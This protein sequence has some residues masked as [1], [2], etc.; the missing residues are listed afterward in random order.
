LAAERQVHL[1]LEG[2]VQGVGM[3]DYVRRRA[4]ALGLV[5]FVRNLSD[6][7]VEVVAEGR[8]DTLAAFTAEL[9]RAPVGRVDRVQEE[10]LEASGR[11]GDF[12]IAATL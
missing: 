11:F 5:G 4:R 8:E 9:R 7:R 10:Y 2:D 12:R 3:R 6:G 1:Y